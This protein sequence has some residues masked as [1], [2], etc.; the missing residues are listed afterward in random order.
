[1]NTRT[2]KVLVVL[3]FAVI[4]LCVIAMVYSDFEK[5]KKP[6]RHV[7]DTGVLIIYPAMTEV[8]Y[9][10]DSFYSFYKGDCEEC[11]THSLTVQKGNRYVLGL[12]AYDVFYHNYNSVDDIELDRSVPMLDKYHTVILLHNEYVTQKVYD[13]ITSHPNVIYLY[14][15]ALYGL[16]SID[17]NSM[18][19]ERGHGY[20]TPD[21]ENGFGWIHENTDEE[22]DCTEWRFRNVTNGIQLDCYP[23]NI[24]KTDTELQKYLHNYISSK[25]LSKS[26]TK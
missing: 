13:E 18:T 22:T 12:N 2:K 9:Q 23:E 20:P 6:E 5:R 16:V 7:L 1:M 21:I 4:I 8:A 15:N 3:V 19:L 10:P 26:L 24:I 17:S 11:R 14:P 25:A